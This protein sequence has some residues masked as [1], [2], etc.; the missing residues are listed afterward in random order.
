MLVTQQPVLRKFWYPVMLVSDLG[1]GS[2]N[3]PKAF[4]LLGERIVVWKTAGGK[5]AALK[6]RCC[7]RT[8]RLSKGCIQGEHLAC[9]YHGWEYDAEGRCVRI[10]QQETNSI[11]AGAAVPAYLTEEK[12]GYV[13][14]ALEEPLRPIFD[15]AEDHDPK[16]RRIQQFNVTWKTGAL[17]LMEN[18]FDAAHFAFV[19][20]GTFGQFGHN[21]PNFFSLN[22]TDYGFEAETRLVINNP[23]ESHQITGSTLPTTERHFRNQWHLPFSRR[24]GLSYPNGLEHLIITI[25]TPIDDVD[26]DAAVDLSRRAEQHM[27]SD[28]PG[29]IMRQRLQALLAEAGEVEK[30]KTNTKGKPSPTWI[31][32]IL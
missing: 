11:P 17:R 1:T 4:T 16:Y 9:G 27:Q 10:P 5:L 12:Y 2:E 21:K 28:R 19:H 18:S 26:P 13:W 8:A 22:E 6:D 25:A 15:I 20:Q 32:E 3:A 14:V 7:H 23:P 29:I 24:L 30:F 31:Q